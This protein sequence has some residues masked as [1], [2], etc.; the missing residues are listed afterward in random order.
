MPYTHAIH[1]CNTLTPQAQPPHLYKRAHTRA[2]TCHTHMHSHTHVCC[3]FCSCS[4]FTG[5]VVLRQSSDVSATA[6]A[7]AVV[8]AAAAAAPAASLVDRAAALHCALARPCAHPCLWQSRRTWR[9]WRPWCPE[10]VGL[11]FSDTL[12]LLLLHHELRRRA[13]E[14]DHGLESNARWALVVVA[15]QRP[16]LLGGAPEGPGGK[17]VEAP[18]LSHLPLSVHT[19][20]FISSTGNLTPPNSWGLT[21]KIVR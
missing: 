9:P 7:P 19:V 13:G 17:P 12:P 11:Q 16:A 21:Y 18:A 3:H 5:P 15:W 14:L 4:V 1:T 8:L 10:T 6:K 2:H 20:R